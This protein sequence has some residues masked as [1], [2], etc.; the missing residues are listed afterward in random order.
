[1]ASGR[2][3]SSSQSSIRRSSRGRRRAV[4]GGEIVVGVLHRA[5]QDVQLIVQ[6]VECRSGD[7]QLAV[8]QLELVGALA[9]HPVPLP[10]ALRAELA[11]PAPTTALGQGPAAPTT[12]REFR[13]DERVAPAQRHTLATMTRWFL[14]VDLDQFLAAVEVRR[15]PE[16]RGRPVVVGGNGDPTVPRQVV[17][18]ASYEA[19]AFGVRSGMPLRTAAGAAR[20]RVPAVGQAEPTSRRPPR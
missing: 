6:L 17:A 8:A 16:L 10:A 5:R 2:A 9:G 19:R 3:A 11:R 15:H 14:H 13:H 12:P 4:D 1:M 7:H 18:T 20:C